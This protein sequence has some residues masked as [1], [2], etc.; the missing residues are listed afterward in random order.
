MILLHGVEKIYGRG[1]N[2][3]KALNEIDLEIRQGEMVGIM[4]VSGS[5]KSTLLNI[6]GCIDRPTLGSYYLNG[7][8]VSR[9]NQVTLARLRNSCFG[10][11]VQQFAPL[12]LRQG[13]IKYQ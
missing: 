5:G 10:F 3:V 11:V 12:F 6:I 2:S 8:D 13:S 7:K 4:G 9:M 1:D